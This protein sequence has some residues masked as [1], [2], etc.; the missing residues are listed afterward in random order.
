MIL[1]ESYKSTILKVEASFC[2][3]GFSEDP[4]EITNILGIQP[5]E[6]FRKGEKQ[7][8]KFGSEIEQKTNLWALDSSTKS[9][10]INVHLRQLLAQLE[11]K[12]TLIKSS[13]NPSFSILWEGNYL[14]AGS[15]PFFEKDVIRGIAKIGADL[16]QDIYQIDEDVQTLLLDRYSGSGK[17]GSLG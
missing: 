5:S 12:E 17:I 8:T 10:D 14:Y 1:S 7:E 16:W 11:G 4:D 3:E 13:W 2:F 9:K 6:C 15:G